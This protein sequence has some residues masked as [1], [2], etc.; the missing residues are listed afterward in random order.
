MTESPLQCLCCTA[1]LQHQLPQSFFLAISTQSHTFLV[2]MGMHII[3]IFMNE[4]FPVSLS[5]PSCCHFQLAC[6]CLRLW[7][8]ILLSIQSASFKVHLIHLK[9]LKQMQDMQWFEL[10]PNVWIVFLE[11]LLILNSY[12]SSME[13]WQRVKVFKHQMNEH[14]P[15]WKSRYQI[16]QQPEGIESLKRTCDFNKKNHTGERAI[17]IILNGVMRC[18]WLG[19]EW[20]GLL[21]ENEGRSF[22]HGG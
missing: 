4:P 3:C 22:P 12:T 20:K 10:V 7:L 18:F 2:D 16:H 8:V 19:S 6:P 5:S 21:I 15:L 9:C 13:Q 11:C 14:I 17:S 1:I